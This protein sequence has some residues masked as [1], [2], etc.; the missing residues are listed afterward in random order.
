[1]MT[2][3]HQKRKRDIMYIT[4]MYRKL[5]CVMISVE[6]CFR[7]NSR[8]CDEQTPLFI[9]SLRLKSIQKYL[10]VKIEYPQVAT[11][12]TELP[13]S[14]HERQPSIICETDPTVER[15]SGSSHRTRYRTLNGLHRREEE[16]GS[17]EPG[18]YKTGGQTL[19]HDP[20]I[21]IAAIAVFW[22]RTEIRPQLDDCDKSLK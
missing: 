14:P 6:G 4:R 8:S 3:P 1:M 13:R 10:A 5:A 17:G 11:N 18:P 20:T 12:W 16:L 15:G 7:S 2:T 21:P 22:N 19:P 9:A